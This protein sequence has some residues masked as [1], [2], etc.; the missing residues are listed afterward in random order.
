MMA[1]DQNETAAA[2]RSKKKR[3]LVELLREEKLKLTERK[4]LKDV[5]L[6]LAATNLSFEKQSAWN[7]SLKR[8]KLNLMSR[9]TLKAGE[10]ALDPPETLEAS[11]LASAQTFKDV[12]AAATASASSNQQEISDQEPS[13]LLPD[14]NLPVEEDFCDIRG[15]S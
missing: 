4:D 10:A 1:V 11:N 13:F 9:E 7:E 15:L 3:S 2:K 5:R 14:L 8:I 6:E 12:S